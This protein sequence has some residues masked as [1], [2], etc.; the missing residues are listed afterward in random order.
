M[1]KRAEQ[2]GHGRRSSVDMYAL[3]KALPEPRRRGAGLS[4][5][6]MRRTS[7]GESRELYRASGLM[8]VVFPSSVRSSLSTRSI[9]CFALATASFFVGTKVRSVDREMSGKSAR[10][11]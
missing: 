8:T 1:L 11:A 5:E 4:R 2:E 6:S 10:V 7:A 9:F 3:N